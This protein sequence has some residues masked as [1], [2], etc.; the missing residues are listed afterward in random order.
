[1]APSSKGFPLAAAQR[2]SILSATIWTYLC[3]AFRFSR[4]QDRGL[5]HLHVLVLVSSSSCTQKGEVLP[6]EG[7]QSQYESPALGL[8]LG[9]SCHCT[10]DPCNSPQQVLVQAFKSRYALFTTRAIACCKSRCTSRRRLGAPSRWQFW[11]GHWD[12]WGPRHVLANRPLIALP[13]CARR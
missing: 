6:V 13:F 9:Y 4:G 8:L 5:Y 12:T 7:P 10:V 3:H 2:H 11:V 1:M